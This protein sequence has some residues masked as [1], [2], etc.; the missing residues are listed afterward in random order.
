MTGLH[1]SGLAGTWYPDDPEILARDVDAFL[2]E[3]RPVDPEVVAIIVPHAGY[4]YS[5]RA[6]GAAWGR[7]PRGRWRRAVVL[8]PS[9]YESFDGAAVLDVEGFRTPLGKVAI[10]REALSELRA[11]P[12][13][14]T[15]P[16]AFRQEHAVEIQLPFVQRVDPDLMVVPLLVSG[17]VSGLA[18]VLRELDDGRS[19]FVVSTDFTHYG[20]RFDYLPFPPSD[21]ASVAAGL[22]RIDLGAIDALCRQDRQAFIS[23]V[24]RTGATV[25]GRDSLEAWLMAFPAG[26]SGRVRAYYTS[27]DVTGD[28]E[29]SVSYAAITF[30]PISRAPG[31][32]P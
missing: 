26:L 19:L 12:V 21:V 5:G 8:A 32:G 31:P 30:A 2:E 17:D 11:F 9:H 28:F 27:L 14:D 6:A 3:G 16:G 23:E 7:I 25:C 10:D 18:P 13:V 1:S 29:H 24:G 20:D 4:R 15:R 22:R